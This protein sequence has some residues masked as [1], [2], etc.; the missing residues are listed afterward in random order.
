[1]A[2]PGRHS[3]DPQGEGG[4]CPLTQE[5]LRLCAAPPRGS[6]ECAPH[7]QAAARAQ[8]AP[9]GSG[10]S[11]GT[12]VGDILLQRRMCTWATDGSLPRPVP[13]QLNGPSPSPGEHG[14]PPGLGTEVRA[15]EPHT[16][17]GGSS[18]GAHDGQRRGPGGTAD[19]TQDRAKPSQERSLV[20]WGLERVR[21]RE[22]V[23]LSPMSPDPGGFDPPR[24]ALYPVRVQQGPSRWVSSGGDVWQ[25]QDTHRTP[26]GSNGLPAEAAWGN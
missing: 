11:V 24:S 9:L 3:T 5:A 21:T 15:A 13:Q 16:R 7:G 20:R 25:E 8:P 12:W 1:M 23:L 22:A 10:T 26:P 19:P 6:Q 17:L 2:F 14:L 18:S 4:P